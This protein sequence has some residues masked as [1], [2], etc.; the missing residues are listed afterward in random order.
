MSNAEVEAKDDAACLQFG[1]V[2]G[3]QVY[4]DCRL[5]LR[6]ER[7]SDDRARRLRNIL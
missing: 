2:K 3:T 5:R 4:V 1:A 7:N 6:S